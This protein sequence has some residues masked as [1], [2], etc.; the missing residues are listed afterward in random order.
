MRHVMSLELR[1]AAYLK[2]D[3]SHRA[4]RVVSDRLFRATSRSSFH[5]VS[6]SVSRATSCGIRHARQVKYLELRHTA[7]L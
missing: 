7:Y 4:V 1:Q 3:A 6:R 5:V 2:L